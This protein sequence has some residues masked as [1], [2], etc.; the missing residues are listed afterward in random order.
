MESSSKLKLNKAQLTDIIQNAFG[1][2][3][4][5][6]NVKENHDGWFNALYSVAIKGMNEVFIKVAPPEHVPCLRYEK[7]IIK[8]ETE[9]LRT[10]EQ[11]IEIPAPKVLFE[12]YNKQIIESDYFIM[13]KLSGS[14]Y[15]S[16][17]E[18][19]NMEDRNKIDR[20]KGQIS[21]SINSIK[22]DTFGLFS[23]EKPK[24]NSWKNAFLQMLKEIFIDAYEFNVKLPIS[25]YKVEEIF[26]EQ[27]SS[28]ESITEPSLVHWDLHDGNII[29]AEDKTIQGIIDCD[30]A[31][32]G[33]PAM[34]YFFNAFYPE[35]QMFFEGYGLDFR[36]S[37]GFKSRRMLYDFY[38]TLI[39]V[40]ECKSRKIKDEQHLEWADLMFR[41]QLRK[42]REA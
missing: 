9:V 20:Q 16:I 12:D 35:E 23:H 25:L 14:S 21:R 30:R 24:F 13:E 19:L 29:I 2:G 26:L 10:F 17:K 5:I 32:W 3:A 34:E 22:N 4:E 40:T 28:L 38:L 42:L 31:L 8:T 15:S 39:F 27:S 1:S 33:D 36:E 6:I 37:E 7:N 18:K 41:N 11:H